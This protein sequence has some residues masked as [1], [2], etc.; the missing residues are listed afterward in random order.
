MRKLNLS[1]RGVLTAGAASLGGLLLG[2]CDQSPNGGL[3]RSI[4]D[5]GEKLTYAAQRALL[6][7]SAMAPEFT[8]ADI[9]STFKANGNTDPDSD[10]YVAMVDNGFKDFK[11][12][13]DGLVEHPLEL[14]LEQLRAM[15]ARTQITR[16]DCVEGWSCIGKWTGVPL[17]QILDQAGVK[18][19]A[20]YVVF[21]C[22]DTMDDGDLNGPTPFYGSI[23]LDDGH[24]PQT[25]LAYDMNDKTLP[26]AHGAPLR[27]R[28]ERQLGYKMSKYIMRI[29]LVDSY[30]KFGAGKGGYWEDNGYDWY[31]GI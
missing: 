22:A 18:Q 11:L 23:D 2:G 17:S 27:L 24:H 10:D 31:G 12:K 26:V 20:Q 16:H 25:I 7:R 21:H 5:S 29:E 19:T 1:R 13:V 9:G 8:E 15:P 28:V 3:V 30:A 6:G 14:S 4:L